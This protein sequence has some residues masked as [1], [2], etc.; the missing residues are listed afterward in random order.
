ME[1]WVFIN[2][3]V[4]TEDCVAAFLSGIEKS[5]DA[6]LLDLMSDLTPI[7]NKAGDNK[8]RFIW[9]SLPNFGAVKGLY[10]DLGAIAKGPQEAY[11]SYPEY[12]V[13]IGAF[14][15]GID[16]NV[17]VYDLLFEMAWRKKVDLSEWLHRYS[18]RRY[19]ISSPELKRMWDVLL[20]KVYS[21]KVH[22][23]PHPP[24]VWEPYYSTGS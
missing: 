20:P 22:I 6:I 2:S 7:Y 13:G 23:Y 9:G 10:G 19:G 5:E 12:M 4:W 21:Q 8:K 15:E 18:E 11:Q 3:H 1:T 17:V 24:M 16:Q 14:M